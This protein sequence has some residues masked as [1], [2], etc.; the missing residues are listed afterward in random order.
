MSKG[1]PADPANADAGVR[2]IVDSVATVRTT[3]MHNT[4]ENAEYMYDLVGGSSTRGR[5]CPHFEPAMHLTPN[6]KVEGYI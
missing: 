4:L 6:F 5:L 2:K 3:Q 1:P